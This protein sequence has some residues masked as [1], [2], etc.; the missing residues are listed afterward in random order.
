MSDYSNTFKKIDL[1]GSLSDELRKQLGLLIATP[2]GTCVLYRDFGL[3]LSC[4]DMPVNIARNMLAAELAAR[5]DK[6]IPALRL[7]RVELEQADSNG[8]LYLKIEVE[9]GNKSSGINTGY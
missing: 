8:R 4:L 6:F 5:I 3:D 2:L 1:G 9:N 7:V